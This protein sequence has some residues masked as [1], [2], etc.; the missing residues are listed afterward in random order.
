MQTYVVVH[1][2]ERNTTPTHAYGIAS[3]AQRTS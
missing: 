3:A 2:S 1:V